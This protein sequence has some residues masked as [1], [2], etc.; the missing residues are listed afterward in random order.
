[1]THE[2]ARFVQK[3][4]ADYSWSIGSLRIPAERL[5]RYIAQCE[6]TERD[7]RARLAE[8]T[9]QLTEFA[10]VVGNKVPDE[11]RVQ[12]AL[13]TFKALMAQHEQTQSN[14]PA[15]AAERGKETPK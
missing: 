6:A 3:A 11:T 12:T 13:R 5:S 14:G 15:I 2:H 8:A 7:L 1:V 10:M 9:A 4:V